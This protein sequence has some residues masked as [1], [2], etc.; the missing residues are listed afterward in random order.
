M[1]RARALEQWRRSGAICVVCDNARGDYISLKTGDRF[2]R[3]CHKELL[4]NGR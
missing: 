4:K 2:C 3:R 1:L